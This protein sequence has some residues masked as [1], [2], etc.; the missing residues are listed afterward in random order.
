MSGPIIFICP[1][2][3]MCDEVSKV[4][5]ELQEDVETIH[6]LSSEAI[7]IVSSEKYKEAKAIVALPITCRE[8]AEKVSIPVIAF[9]PTSFDLLEAFYQARSYA[10][11]IS[12]IGFFFPALQDDLS[13]IEQFLG[14]RVHVFSYTRSEEREERVQEALQQKTKIA[15]VTGNQGKRAVEQCGGTAV[16]VPV[17]HFA[18]LQALRIT[19]QVLASKESEASQRQWLELL[20]N[21]SHDGIIATDSKGQITTFNRTAEKFLRIPAQAAMKL[22]VHTMEAHDPLKILLQGPEGNGSVKEDVLSLQ[23]KHVL[24]HRASASDGGP[25][26]QIIVTFR[27][28]SEIERLQRAVHRDAIRR[29]MVANYTFGDIIG[30]SKSIRTL[31]EYAAMYAGTDSTILMTGE[32]GVGKEVFAQGIHNASNRRKG[33]F[34][35]INCVTIPE[36]LLESEL[37]GYE[38]GSF[39]GARKE[40]KRGLFEYA[41]GGTIFL[42]EIGEMPLPQ[43]AR[44]L[45]V[46]QEKEI[47]RVGGDKVFPVDVRIIAATNQNLPEEVRAKRFRQ[48]LYYR[49]NVLHFHIPP[50]R[51]RREDILD[52]VSY[53]IGSK[54]AKF[55]HTPAPIDDKCLGI[56]KE[57]DWPGNVRQL[58]NFIERYVVL[59]EKEAFTSLLRQLLLDKEEKEAPSAGAS[60]V[61]ASSDCLLIEIDT[62][63]NIEKQIINA[64]LPQHGINELARRLGVSRTTIWRKLKSN[65]SILEH[66]KR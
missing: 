54:A 17:G 56:L 43:Q 53:F 45:R 22:N 37:F 12:Y 33:P 2:K 28:E 40:G 32:T 30:K 3:E 19:Q 49:L 59:S 1:Y 23:D 29:G 61:Q 10:D 7:D 60:T 42:D 39:T 55:G 41:N 35:G 34:V 24:V 14:I 16:V 5:K 50:L 4:G 26:K 27:D 31:T 21:L 47:R 8:I 25:N 65:G 15:I 36:N 48:D 18:I 51:E 9:Y 57:Y 44:L 58:E 66:A 11:E 38:G 63:A 64:L 62:I 13:R 20:L 46:L 6:A 52:L